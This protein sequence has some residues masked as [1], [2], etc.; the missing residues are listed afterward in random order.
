MGSGRVP[1]I[2]PRHPPTPPDVR[3]SASGG[4]TVQSSSVL[5]TRRSEFRTLQ[6]VERHQRVVPCLSDQDSDRSCRVLP[7]RSFVRHSIQC[8][9]W[10]RSF[11][12]PF[13]R[14]A[15]LFV[16]SSNATMAS[17]DFPMPLS[18]GISPGQGLFFPFAPLGSTECRQWFSGFAFARTL[19]P[20]TLPHCPF[21]F[22][23]SNVCLPPFRAG[24]LRRRPGG[25]ATVGS[26]SPRREHFTPPDQTPAGHTSA[27][28]LVREF[29][30]GLDGNPAAMAVRAPS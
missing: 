7:L 10:L 11:L 15:F 22:L 8:F 17:A 6:R 28:S 27:D 4:W 26:T 1:G 5:D 24:S 29:S 14:N 19:A 18:T 2:A 12:R 25:S 23:R 21:V 13:A 9:S 3:F 20:D 16:R 30:R